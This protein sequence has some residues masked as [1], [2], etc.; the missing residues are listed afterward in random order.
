MA[1]DLSVKQYIPVPPETKASKH[2]LPPKE[3]T[4]KIPIEELVPFPAALSP[5][6]N[7]QKVINFLWL[8]EYTNLLQCSRLLQ[9]RKCLQE[10][11]T[12]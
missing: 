12:S 4:P 10:F 3:G 2:K 8:K 1:V 6:N 11:A 9:Y 5:E 7:F